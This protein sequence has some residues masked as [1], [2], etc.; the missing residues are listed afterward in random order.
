MIQA[1]IG[2]EMV[3]SS[4]RIDLFP[5]GAGTPLNGDANFNST[6]STFYEPRL[7]QLDLRFTKIFNLGRG[8]VRG[9]LD[10]F[11]VFN[12][13]SASNLLPAYDSGPYPRATQ[14]MG[15]RLL[16]FGGQ[17]DW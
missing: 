3:V 10:I 14:I 17:F 8:R 6:G 12:A 9:W 2:H 4:E 5:S 7:T 16:R 13:N 15:G 1:Q 11:N